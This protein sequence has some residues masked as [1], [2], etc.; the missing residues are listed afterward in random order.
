MAL[1][2]ENTTQ[3]GK[4]EF[5]LLFL[6]LR[7]RCAVKTPRKAVRR[8]STMLAVQTTVAKVPAFFI[9]KKDSRTHS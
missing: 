3:G 5:H 6:A 2:G 1:R 7:R 8:N 9:A 4:A